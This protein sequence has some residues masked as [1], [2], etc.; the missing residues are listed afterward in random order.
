MEVAVKDLSLLRKYL[1]EL[2]EI[3]SNARFTANLNATPERLTIT[4]TLYDPLF[5]YGNYSAE[6][7]NTD[8]TASFRHGVRLKEIGRASCRERGE[9]A[10]GVGAVEMETEEVREALR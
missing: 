6:S 3:Q 1:R 7:L 8:F 10:G 4:G 2:P 5:L 9:I